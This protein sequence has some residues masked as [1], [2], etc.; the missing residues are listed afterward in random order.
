MR[1]FDCKKKEVINICD[2]RRLGY[3]ADVE[4]NPANGCIEAIIV[5]GPCSFCGFLG[6]EKEY[7]IPWRCIRQMGEEI[8]LVEVKLRDVEKPLK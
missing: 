2:C 8:I 7:I 1:I 6:H 5:P 3:V 4:F